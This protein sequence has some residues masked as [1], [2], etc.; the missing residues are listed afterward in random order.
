MYGNLRCLLCYLQY[1][2]SIRTST[3][4]FV[5]LNRPHKPVTKSTIARW[6]KTV[7][8]YAGINMDIFKPHSVRSAACSAVKGHV[9]IDTILQTAGWTRENTFRKFYDRPVKCNDD[10]GEALLSKVRKH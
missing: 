5:A 8:K 4:L 9:P 6:I 10:F 2:E 7:L 3:Q 1:T